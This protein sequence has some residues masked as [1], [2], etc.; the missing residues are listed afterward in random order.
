MKK[1]NYFDC[2]RED[3]PHRRAYDNESRFDSSR[4][5]HKPFDLFD[6]SERDYE[7]HEELDLFDFDVDDD[8]YMESTYPLLSAALKRSEKNKSKKGKGK[9]KSKRKNKNIKKEFKLL[10][11]GVFKDLLKIARF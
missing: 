11:K 7:S 9:N 4:P 1:Y 5:L 10:K 3:H 6:F 8:D 2:C